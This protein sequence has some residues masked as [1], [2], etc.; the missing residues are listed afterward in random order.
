MTLELGGRAL[1]GHNLGTFCRLG[2]RSENMHIM[3][4]PRVQA[5][6]KVPLPQCTPF[7]RFT[8]TFGAGL[9]C[10]L[11]PNWIRLGTLKV[12]FAVCVGLFL[13]FAHRLHYDDDLKA[14][15]LPYLGMLDV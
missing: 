12:S 6:A 1:A 14:R 8:M 4:P 13:A 10:T 9:P 15:C 3:L 5:G 2:H 7:V 11:G